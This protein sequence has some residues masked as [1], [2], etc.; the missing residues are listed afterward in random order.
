MQQSLRELL[1]KYLSD[2]LSPEE[3]ELF[4]NMLEDIGYE[5]ELE[6]IV[7]EYI[8]ERSLVGDEDEDLKKIS[9]LRLEN[10]L[11]QEGERKDTTNKVTR[12]SWLRWAAAVI[13]LA[14]TATYLW[15]P[16]KEENKT[17]T[18]KQQEN[19]II[20]IAA[21]TITPGG[22]KAVLTLADGSSILL[23]SAANGALAS[24]GST[25]ILKTGN[26]EL[27]YERAG[28]NT[29]VMMNT[30]STP[31]GGQYQVVLPDGTKARLNAGSSIT[32]PASFIGKTRA[33]SITG[34]IFL[35]VTKDQHQPF[36]VTANNTSITVLGTAFNINAYKEEPLIR[37]T[38][39]DGSVIVN[40][41]ARPLTL[42]PGQQAKV[43]AGSSIVT[44]VEDPNMEQVLAWTNGLF[45]FE[46]SD[47]PAVM[48][49]LEYWYGISVVYEGKL[50][51]ITFKGKM[52]R[53]VNLA[54]VLEGLQEMDLRFKL[55]GKKLIVSGKDSK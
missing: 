17:K 40:A 52:Y 39:V 1:E 37:T 10:Q 15:Y 49:Q 7:D 33:V 21:A 16:G 50:P 53:N 22:N 18:A 3:T 54:D 14:G 23:D 19:N 51:A 13:L 12:M 11:H 30:I 42:K 31:T 48:R 32:F 41:G 2:S 6:Q 24:Q 29:E 5:G 20:P 28:K 9:F 35:E 47:L 44:L 27:V 43:P 38:L 26:G 46:G 25:Q 55:E 8:N 4:R 45:N 34:E 36:V